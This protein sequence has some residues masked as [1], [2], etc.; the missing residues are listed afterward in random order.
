SFWVLKADV[1]EVCRNAPI[2][3]QAWKK[4]MDGEYVLD[5]GRKVRLEL[6][7]SEGAPT[8]PD[9]LIAS[10]KLG[11]LSLLLWNWNTYLVHGVTYDEYIYPNGQ[12]M[13]EIREL[14]LR[15]PF[16]SP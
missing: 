14:R 11:Q 7:Y 2:E 3:F 12:R 5:D 9:Q 6:R 13:F 8:A 1:G 4:I 15:D 16:L 10:L